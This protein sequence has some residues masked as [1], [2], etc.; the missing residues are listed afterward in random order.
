MYFDDVRITDLQSSLG[1]SQRA[2]CQ[3]NALLGTPFCRGEEAIDTAFGHLFGLGPRLERWHR[4][5]LGPGPASTEDLGHA[6]R[7]PRSLQLVI[8]MGKL[9]SS[10]VC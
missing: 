9:P 4:H 3:L 6:V 7:R 5:V 8:C 10:M 2:F 1:S